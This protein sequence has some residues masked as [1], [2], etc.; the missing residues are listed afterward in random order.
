ML[1]DLRGYGDSGK[2]LGGD[3]HAAYS[4]RAM[5]R[6]QVKVMHQPGFDRFVVV[7]GRLQ[8]CL[9][10][11]V[12]N[13]FIASPTMADSKTGALGA[14]RAWIDAVNQNDIDGIVATFSS[15]ASFFGTSTKTL[16]TSP[17]GIKKYFEVV[18]EQYAPL[19]V[20]LGQVTVIGMSPDS[21]V[22][23]GYDKWTMTIDGKPAEGIGRLNIAVALRDGRWK[24]V[25]F[26]RSIM[27][28]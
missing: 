5:A 15:D 23:T 2:P 13:H 28:N 20:E 10:L 7:V 11:F 19:A 9:C 21:A 8:A 1:I 25:S 24:M 16:V 4:M 14:V 26:H 6:D 12:I 18:H 27:P 3:N 17:D 22:V